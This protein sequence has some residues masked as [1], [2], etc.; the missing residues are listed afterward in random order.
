[1][2]LP[3]GSVGYLGSAGQ[4]SPG[5]IC[6]DTRKLQL[7]LSLLKTWLGWMATSHIPSSQCWLSA[8]SSAWAVNQSTFMWAPSGVLASPSRAAGLQKGVCRNQCPKKQGWNC[9]E[10]LVTEPQKSGCITSTVSCPPETSRWAC[11]DSRRGECSQVWRLGGV[12]P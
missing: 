5:V 4:C 8:K 1:M 6:V 10:L 2:I 3:H 12:A 11:P 7:R 9:T